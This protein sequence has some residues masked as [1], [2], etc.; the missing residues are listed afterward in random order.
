MKLR[1]LISVCFLAAACST[2]K[3]GVSATERREVRRQ[4]EALG[5]EERSIAVFERKLEDL[6][7]KIS[8]GDTSDLRIATI[9]VVQRTPGYF[10]PTVKTIRVV[11]SV[12]GRT[13]PII[14]D[15]SVNP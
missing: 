7:A 9:E 6:G 10:P 1:F 2:Q 3:R 4:I 8:L 14:I 13:R 15:V 11:Y 12:I 5:R